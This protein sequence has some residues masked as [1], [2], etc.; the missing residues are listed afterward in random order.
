MPKFFIKRSKHYEDTDGYLVS[1][2]TPFQF[3]TSTDNHSLVFLVFFQFLYTTCIFF[4]PLILV[5]G[6]RVG[7]APHNQLWVCLLSHGPCTLQGLGA[8]PFPPTLFHQV[9]EKA[10]GVTCARILAEPGYMVTMETGAALT[11]KRETPAS[12]SRTP[13]VRGWSR[14]NYPPLS[15][16]QG[17]LLFPEMF[18]SR[19]RTAAIDFRQLQRINT[20]FFRIIYLKAGLLPGTFELIF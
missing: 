7:K 2:L 10:H 1:S 11:S 3:T 9:S 15:L 4:M 12:A 8:D 18:P 19:P 17:A 16:L 13:L 20:Y 5:P 14:W 6:G